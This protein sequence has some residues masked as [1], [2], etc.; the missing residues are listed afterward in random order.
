MD[1]ARELLLRGKESKG[2]VHM[3]RPPFLGFKWCRPGEDGCGGAGAKSFSD[4]ILDPQR[5]SLAS[6]TSTTNPC[7]LTNAFPSL[8]FSLSPSPLPCS[9]LLAPFSLFPSPTLFLAQEGG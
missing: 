7:P 4:E 5:R 3:G 8:P 1:A 6:S 9:L 2:H